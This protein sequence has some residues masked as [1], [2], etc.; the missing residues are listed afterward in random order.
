MDG[1]L[2]TASQQPMIVIQQEFTSSKTLIA[3]C[4]SNNTFDCR[5]KTSV[6]ATKNLC[7]VLVLLCF[8]SKGALGINWEFILT[9]D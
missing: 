2:G 6:Q 8:V 4:I 3:F 5:I 9:K 1:L 7:C